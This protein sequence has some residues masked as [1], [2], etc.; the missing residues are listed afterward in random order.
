MR[1][2]S[3]LLLVSALGACSTTPPPKFYSLPGATTAAG[4]T[5]D[6]PGLR[7]GPFL[8]PDYLRRPNII[9]RPTNGQLDIAEFERWA[10][11]L[12]NDFLRVLGSQLGTALGTGRVSTYPA[13]ARFEPDYIV[14]GQIV[15]F[16]GSL[17]GAVTLDVHW[18]VT[19][20]NDDTVLVAQRSVIVESVG[21]SDYPSLVDAHTRA[22]QRLSAEIEVQL[23][24]A[25]SGG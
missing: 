10:G 9:T 22:V 11:S 2:L 5:S 17:S 23:R 1:T 18:I 21:G 12:E 16:D 15:T 20:A 25:K 13:E 24:R 3:I 19:S 4:S 14:T 6:G 7:V 8:F